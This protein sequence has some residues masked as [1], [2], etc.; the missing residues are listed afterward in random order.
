M[1]TIL[2]VDDEPTVRIPLEAFLQMSG[3]Q[4]LTAENADEAFDHLNET[5][6]D[7]M[8][9]NINMLGMNGIELT[10]HVTERYNVKVIVLT[11]DDFHDEAIAAGA[12]KY[13]RK[14]VRFE[15]FLKLIESIFNTGYLINQAIKHINSG[16]IDQALVEL[17]NALKIDVFGSVFKKKVFLLNTI[18]NALANDNS[19]NEIESEQIE[20]E[21]K[22]LFIAIEFEE[23]NMSAL[24]GAIVETLESRP[25]NSCKRDNLTTEVLRTVWPGL[26]GEKRK[27]FEKRITTALARLRRA[28]VVKQYQ[29]SKNVRIRL[30]NNYITQL[31]RLKSNW[32]RQL[33]KAIAE[34]DN[35]D[36]II[37]QD[38]F[39][40]T[41]LSAS[42][43][44]KTKQ[45][46]T[47]SSYNYSKIKL[48]DLP[49]IVDPDFHANQN[50]QDAYEEEFEHD[51]DTKRLLGV[52]TND[53]PQDNDSVKPQEEAFQDQIDAGDSLE[54]LETIFENNNHFEINSVFLNTLQV[55]VK[56]PSRPFEFKIEHNPEFNRF[57]VKSYFEI[58]KKSVSAL[59]ALA[60]K[61]DFTS[62]LGTTIINDKRLFVIHKTL[63]TLYTNPKQISEMIIQSLSEM[64]KINEIIKRHKRHNGL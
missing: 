13:V 17:N 32:K 38:D 18:R 58:I 48:P 12:I 23:R 53:N 47:S 11:G 9:T 29:T 63:S 4:I 39:R 10:R 25:N 6:I 31:E 33:E 56:H 43:L 5:H 46:K 62:T 24:K 19:Y 37:Q 16:N 36:E 3:Y 35:K 50:D 42:V 54:F 45:I 34:S 28:K 8:V 49:E 22:K 21:V 1:N 57:I 59:F 26:R 55:T 41:P 7:L 61:D 15:S 40:E 44:D 20:R 14:P 60:G 30:T 51:E 52:L 64:I 2:L 27:I